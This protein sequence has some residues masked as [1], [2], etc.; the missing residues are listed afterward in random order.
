MLL[1]NFSDKG[2][3]IGYTVAFASAFLCSFLATPLVRRLALRLDAVDHPGS[4]K[5]HLRTVPR[6]GGLALF[7]GFLLPLLFFSGFPASGES[8]LSR[9]FPHGGPI[10]WPFI[11]ASTMI[12]ILG[13]VDDLYG[14]NA[15]R[16]FP[17]QIAAGILTYWAGFRIEHLSL[18]FT[19]GFDLGV[20][21]PVVTL[22]WTVGVCNAINLIDGLDGLAAGISA[23]GAFTLFVTSV[24]TTGDSPILLLSLLLIGSALGFLP[25]NFHPARIFMGD[26]GSLFLGFALAVLSLHASQKSTLAFPFLIPIVALG[27]PIADTLVSM[28][29]RWIK[30]TPIFSADQEHFHHKLILKGFSQPQAVLLLYGISALLGCSSIL[31][32]LVG[33]SFSFYTLPALGAGFVGGLGFLGYAELVNVKTILTTRPILIEADHSKRFLLER[34]AGELHRKKGLERANEVME[35][36]GLLLEADRVSLHLFGENG[37]ARTRAA[38]EWKRPRSN[39][40]SGAWSVTV[41]LKFEEKSIGSLTL[42]RTRLSDGFDTTEETA[43]ASM[44]GDRVG[45]WLLA[46]TDKPFDM[47]SSDGPSPR[48][49]KLTAPAQ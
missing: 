19:G 46:Q 16:K 32:A 45:R 6:L 7:A 12:L 4:R 2:V 42:S 26:S 28:A 15:T 35:E 1:S 49:D 25:Y 37:H 27:L 23:I 34:M 48:S 13:I 40:A 29:R 36:I 30:G 8:G 44:A 39:G 47:D 33:P 21:A 9:F 14:L 24:A 31:M 38:Y 20:F 41:P 43:L 17:V 5:I 10:N 11:I 3:V 18:P 22:L